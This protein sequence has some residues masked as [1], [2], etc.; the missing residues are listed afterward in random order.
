MSQTEVIFVRR[1][2]AIIGSQE[3]AH[4]VLEDMRDLPYQLRIVRDL[5]RKFSCK[6][7]TSGGAPAPSA[8]EGSYEGE[9][10]LDLGPVAL[11]FTAVDSDLL[12][13]ENEPP[14]RAGVRV[15]RQACAMYEPLFPAV[16]VMGASPM[17]ISF[18][19]DQPVYI[20]RSKLCAVRLDSSD[21]S[22]QHARMGYEAGE[23]W[24]EDLG[25][26]N[27]TFVSQQQISGRVNFPPGAPVVLGREIT[28]VGV[29]SEDQ[30]HRAGKVSVAQVERVLS[31]ERRYPIL[32]SVSEVARPARVVVSPGTTFNIG[33]DPASD[34]WLGAPHV[35]RM[36]C[37]VSCSPDGEL[38]VT[39]HSTNGTAYDEGILKRGDVLD[40]KGSPKVLDFGGGVTV[41]ICFDELQERS[42]VMAKG[43]VQVF[44]QKGDVRPVRGVP[45]LPGPDDP[46][47]WTE[48]RGD[49]R[50]V[51]VPPRELDRF[52]GLYRSLELKTKLILGAAVVGLACVV[53]IVVSLLVKV[54]V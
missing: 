53:F 30:I 25:S 32:I 22:A 34:M 17:V 39:D 44:V 43:A 28:V 15:L 24:I 36:H 35:S 50:K 6:A 33:R 14:D 38:S 51:K 27:G 5:G 9:T 13:K 54:F 46:E 19:P 2:Q 40:L 4:V 20:G 23:F 1:P 3:F 47:V 7:I 16:A 31:Q 45:S 8:I 12:L 29:T 48:H 10:S 49:D 18:T 41:A 11:H 37:S 52:R 26:T 42:F 21:I